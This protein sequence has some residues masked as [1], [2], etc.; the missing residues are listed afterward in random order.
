MS[1]AEEQCIQLNRWSCGVPGC[2]LTQWVTGACRHGRNTAS[3]SFM[4]A[5]AN[6][7]EP[8][9]RT[10]AVVSKAPTARDK[11]KT[12]ELVD[13]LRSMNLYEP[14]EDSTKREGVLALLNEMVQTWCKEVFVAKV[15]E[16][17]GL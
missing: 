4:H 16:F 13:Y 9:P 1:K 17:L 8:R 3:V 10:Q 12:Q 7:R 5:F 15:S 2:R 11:S 6:I 14:P